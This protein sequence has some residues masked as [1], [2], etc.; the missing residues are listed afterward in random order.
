MTKTAGTLNDFTNS[1]EY[2]SGGPL[3]ISIVAGDLNADN[4]PDLVVADAGDPDNANLYTNFGTGHAMATLINGG[5]GSFG[6][7]TAHTTRFHP[8]FALPRARANHHRQP[9]HQN[10]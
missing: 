4:K 3:P 6:P 8:P 9:D 1:T 2:D 7:S 10:A 5:S